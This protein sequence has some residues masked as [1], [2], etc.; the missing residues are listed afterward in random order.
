MLREALKGVAVEPPTVS[1]DFASNTA[2]VKVRAERLIN[3]HLV[4]SV[5]HQDSMEGLARDMPRGGASYR[6]GVRPA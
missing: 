3:R 5:H 4:P 6:A 1:L 2:E